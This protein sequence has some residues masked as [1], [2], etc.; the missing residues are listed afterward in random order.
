M[1]IY[2]KE[3][4]LEAARRRFRWLYSEFPNVF[5]D[6][7]GGKDSTVML[8]LAIEAAT[9]LRRLPVDVV[10]IDQEAEWGAV[11]DYMRDVRAD[12]RVRLH[13]LQVPIR[14]FNA[15]SFDED[16]L[17][18]WEAGKE[19]VWMRPRESDSIHVNAFGTDRFAKLFHGYVSFLH[20][21]E[22][23]ISLAGVRAEESPGRHLVLTTYETYKGETWG[24]KDDPKRGHYSFYPIYDW[25]YTD[26]W[27]AIHEHAWPYTKVYDWQYQYGVPIREMRVSNL[28]HETAV[29][30]LFMLQEL[31]PATWEALTRRLPGI[32]AAGHLERDFYG[33]RQLPPMFRDWREYRDYLLEHLI[34]NAEHKAY[35]QKAFAAYDSRYSGKALAD[36]YRTEVAS[37][38]VND[39]HGTK[40]FAFRAAHM[41]D[42]KNRGKV[43]GRTRTTR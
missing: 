19:D 5:V 3:T 30:T 13:W 33:P 16:W 21:N 36:L 40:L 42:N 12:P 2:L 11:I 39:Y 1:K 34:T 4:T 18:C 26:V 14:L 31:E 22:P 35:F 38:L 28:H 20:P 41:A 29:R 32:N 8:Q 15:T 25:T 9:D 17:H 27:K 23:A 6:F 10:F 43:S 7:S 37:I 24:R